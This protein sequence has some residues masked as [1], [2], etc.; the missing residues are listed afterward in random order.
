[1]KNPFITSRWGSHPVGAVGAQDRIDMVRRFNPDECR[2]A[3]DVENLQKSVQV[4]IK[5]RLRQ[6]KTLEQPVAEILQGNPLVECCRCRHKH[7]L[8]QRNMRAR[9]HRDRC[10]RCRAETWTRAEE[11]P[12]IF[13]GGANT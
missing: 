5:R 12:D 4:A 11:Q 2:Q 10:P 7:H 1:M 9:E 6:L 13:A 3:L 8:E